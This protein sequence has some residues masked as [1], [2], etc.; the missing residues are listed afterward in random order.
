MTPI[1][2]A[3]LAVAVV[4]L[5]CAGSGNEQ[6]NAVLL[7]PGDSLYQ[8]Q[9]P[10]T[11][12]VRF[13]TTEGEFTAEIY[14]DWAPLGADRL[15][16]LVRAGYYAGNRF[17]RVVPGFM[18]QFG[19]HGDPAVNAAWA[20]QR[21][22]DDPVLQTNQRGTL[23]F[24]MAG[25]NTRT[26]QLFINYSDNPQLDAMGFAPLGRITD[27]MTIVD[28][29]YGEYGE[30]A[31][32]GRGPDQRRIRAEGTEYLQRSFPELDYIESAE[33]VQSP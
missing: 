14:R 28:R 26:T 15:Y 33:I 3:A 23:V 30:A 29:L 32:A 16:N 25:P 13:A 6:S 5:A 20:D 2:R 10:D 1:S 8:T 11:F 4:C 27:G 31:P 22:D 24:A 17:F 12:H 9:A 19:I 7:Q 18:V 21:I